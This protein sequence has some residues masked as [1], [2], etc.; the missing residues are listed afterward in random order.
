MLLQFHTFLLHRE[1]AYARIR[2]CS[3]CTRGARR[4]SCIYT[5]CAGL[6]RTGQTRKDKKAWQ[7]PQLP[8]HCHVHAGT[9]TICTTS[10][11]RSIAKVRERQGNQRAGVSIRSLPPQP[12]TQPRVSFR[13]IGYWHVALFRFITFI[14]V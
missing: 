14:L 1:R 3:I 4:V 11:N 7:Q 8:L 6:E 9:R 5:T 2:P 12:Y 13:T 10:N